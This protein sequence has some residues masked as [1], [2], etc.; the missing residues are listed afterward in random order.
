L[1][2]LIIYRLN[3]LNNPSAKNPKAPRLTFK[4]IM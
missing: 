2:Y 3:K 4:V 1:K